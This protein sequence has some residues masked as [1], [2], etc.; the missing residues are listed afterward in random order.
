[1]GDTEPRQEREESPPERG[2]AA[3]APLSDGLFDPDGD[4]IVT[5]EQFAALQGYAP[6]AL[7]RVARSARPAGTPDEE[8]PPPAGTPVWLTEWQVAEIRLDVGVGDQVEWKLIPMDIP[9]LTELF[10][11]RRTVDLQLDLY[12]DA[13]GD[14][15]AY[16]H[17][18]GRIAG[19][20][21]V[22]CPLQ[23]TAHPQGGLVPV[24]GQAW[25]TRLD[26]TTDLPVVIEDHVYG[27]IVYVGED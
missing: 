10:G 17:V 15:P 1:M 6:A 26:R 19:I 12:A 20:E 22:R 5:R 8:A 18:A 25:T 23:V 16:S 4:W 9:W 11:E 2:W 14:A 3:Y 21:V 24:P 13:F 27:Y 7:D